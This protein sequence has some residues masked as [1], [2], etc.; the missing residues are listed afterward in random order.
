MHIKV[1]YLFVL[2]TYHLQGK[3]LNSA[4]DE[5]DI[6]VLIGTSVCNVTSLSKNQLTCKP[7][8]SQPPDL[9][10]EGRTDT[11]KPPTVVVKVGKNL[12]YVIGRLRY[13]HL[14]AAEFPQK[15]MYMMIAGA[16]CLIIIFIII[17]ILYRRKSTESN[18]VLKN[19]QEQ[20]DVLELRVAAECKEGKITKYFDKYVWNIF[21]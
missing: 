19:M 1:I 21:N 11:S 16:C 5:S 14:S 6:V 7:P 13:D 4:S 20:M 12:S 9:T 17:L 3:N 2:L 15:L 18:R 10:D 8:S